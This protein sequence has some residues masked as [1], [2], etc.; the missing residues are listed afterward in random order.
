MNSFYEQ[1]KKI[2]LTLNNMKLAE[3]NLAE[4]DWDFNSAWSW[5]SPV[6]IGV[7]FLSCVS[8]FGA[9]IYYDT[10]SQWQVL[11]TIQKK[12]TELK[13]VFELKHNQSA[14]LPAYQ[15][16]LS[17]IKQ[18]LQDIVKQMP[19]EEEVAGLIIDISQ[20]GI[21]SGLE[22]KLFK[23]APPIHQEFYSELPISIEVTGEYEELLL[24]ISGLAALPRIVTIHDLTIAPLDKTKITKQSK[25]LM[26]VMVKTYYEN[27]DAISGIK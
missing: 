7:I 2:Y 8:V 15:E 13:M 6:R 17:F 1:N 19:M 16:Q 24:F 11:E 23:P 4:I 9:G 26:S 25:M 10:L 22:F 12:E 14:N 18:K 20:T 27:K 5:P 3:L 21:A